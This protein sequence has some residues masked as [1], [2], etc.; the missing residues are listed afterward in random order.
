MCF[1]KTII[2]IKESFYL[3]LFTYLFIY[4]YFFYISKFKKMHL[5]KSKKIVFNDI[6]KK[7]LVCLFDVQFCAH[8]I[9]IYKQIFTRTNKNK[10]K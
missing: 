1:D 6:V 7:F 3:F 9:N 2:L 5:E 4:L 8:S 10:T